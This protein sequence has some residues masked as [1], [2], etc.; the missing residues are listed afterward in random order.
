MECYDRSRAEAR[1]KAARQAAAGGRKPADASEARSTGGSPRFGKGLLAEAHRV[2]T[3]ALQ[4]AVARDFKTALALA[5]L[6]LAGADRVLLTYR[7]RPEA[8]DTLNLE[9]ERL[10][11]ADWLELDEAGPV[12]PSEFTPLRLAKNGH[13]DPVAL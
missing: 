13:L 5:I 11:E 6:G 3:R 7:E 9:L 4:A 1:E 2:K 12:E 10:N 8:G